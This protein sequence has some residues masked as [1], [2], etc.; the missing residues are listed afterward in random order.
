M[1]IRDRNLTVPTWYCGIEVHAHLEANTSYGWV[2]LE[3]RWT[4]LDTQCETDLMQ[5]AEVLESSAE[6]FRDDEAISLE[7][8]WVVDLNE[9]IR[10]MLDAYFGDGDGYLNHTESTA[11]LTEIAGNA[12]DGSPMF[13]LNGQD[14]DWSEVT[15]P[16]F[17]DLPSNSFGLP[18]MEM[19][20]V[21]HYEDMY[22]VAFS[23]YLWFTDD[24][25]TSFDFDVDLYFYGNE[26]FELEAVNAHYVDSTSTPVGIA[27]NE[28][29]A[30]EL[31]MQRKIRVSGDM[32]LA[33][34][35]Q[36]MFNLSTS[37]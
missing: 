4:W 35:M 11:A 36:T 3:D 26:D 20:W 37:G 34:K 14:P 24:E 17:T 12:S 7:L 5:F 19:T 25:T 16:S 31:F 2:S 21:L 32:A 22:G 29:N 23:T 9:S 10:E 8:T 28:A 33:M 13:Q 27:N 18:V 15:G 1:C 6:L 30:M